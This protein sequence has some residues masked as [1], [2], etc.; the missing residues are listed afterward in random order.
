VESKFLTLIALALLAAGC[1]DPAA[2]VATT[3]A[4]ATGGPAESSSSA[5]ETGGITGTVVDDEA[6]PISG[7]NVAATGGPSA[8]LPALKTDASGRFAFTGLLPGSYKVFVESLGYE[9]VAKAI[10]VAA[11]ASADAT[12]ALKAVAIS[13]ARSEVFIG[14]GYIDLAA[15]TPAAYSYNATDKAYQDMYFYIDPDASTAVAATTWQATA[16][17]TA[18]RMGMSLWLATKSC[19]DVCD[20]IGYQAGVSPLLVRADD[21]ADAINGKNG[22][23]IN[24]FTTPR[25]CSPE[26]CTTTPEHWVQI[27]YEQ[28]F[29]T[30]VAVFYVD[31]AP[32][33][34]SPLPA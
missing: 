14:N 6:M 18:K 32:E 31:P 11:G 28:K 21:L 24:P 23:Q 3:S 16:P 30:Y 29:T 34:Y 13:M 1:T 10:T 4:A 15:S 25:S 9:S 27:A 19:N 8:D 33:G 17:G 7:A 2:T 22:Y 12:F 20:Q 5:A 26:V